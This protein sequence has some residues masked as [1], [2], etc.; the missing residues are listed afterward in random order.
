M[1]CYVEILMYDTE[2]VDKEEDGRR[3]NVDMEGEVNIFE[4]LC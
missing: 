4:N 3:K 2:L 1:L